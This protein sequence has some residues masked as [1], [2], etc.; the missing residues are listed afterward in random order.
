MS[1]IASNLWGSGG[2]PVDVWTQGKWLD[3]DERSN[4]FASGIVMSLGELGAQ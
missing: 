1:Q 3:C 2:E 4:S